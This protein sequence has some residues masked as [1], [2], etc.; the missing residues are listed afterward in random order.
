VQFLFEGIDTYE[1]TQ[2]EKEQLLNTPMYN[3]MWANGSVSWENLKQQ[4]KKFE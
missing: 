3:M 2:K 4:I 1:G